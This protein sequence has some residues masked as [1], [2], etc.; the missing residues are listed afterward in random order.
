[1]RR[2][3]A[4]FGLMRT[5][6]FFLFVAL[7]IWGAAVSGV[8]PV[9]AYPFLAI[10]AL[11]LFFPISS[12]P[13]EKI[14]SVRLGLWPLTQWSRVA[15]RLA[16]LALSPLLWLVLAVAVL[17]REGRSV[18]LPAGAVLAAAAVR[19][20]VPQSARR[21]AVGG[22]VP[23]M[24]GADGILVSNHVREMLVLLDTWLALAIAAIGMLW[25]A[26]AH[27]ADP[28]AWPILAMLVGIALSTQ[29]QC[30]GGLDATRY[31]LLPLAAWRVL[32]ARDTAYLAVQTALTAG[33]DPRAGLVFGMTALAAARYP[34]LHA[35][36]RA[37]RWR[38]ASGRVLFG[39]LQMIAGAMLVFAGWAGAATA[40]A[41][42]L[43]S[44]WWGGSVLAQRLRGIDVGGAPRG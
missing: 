21:F 43:G 41:L 19:A 3:L 10:L 27:D 39:T 2:D 33:L 35:S 14:P 1:M 36:L 17:A 29:A 24:P 5:N 37:E 30:G 12:D 38:F 22:A 8:Y 42:W 23:A 44:V 20:R 6:N 32:L 4:G 11:L 13:L 40:A 31:R 16:A 26:T 18:L 7:L 34:A 15:L 28:A 9:S 25:R